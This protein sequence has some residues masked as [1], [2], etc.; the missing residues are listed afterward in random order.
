MY[1][2]KK[3]K[4]IFILLSFI[5]ILSLFILK[6][7]LINLM[8]NNS[9]DLNYNAHIFYYN[10]YANPEF[11]K[12]FRHWNHDVLPHWS[13]KSWDNLPSYDGY[14]TIGSNFYPKLG[15]YSSNNPEIIKKH[16]EM[17]SKAG[18]G[19]IS[20]SWWGKNSFEDK[21]ILS[22]LEIADL[23]DIKVNFHIEPFINRTVLSTIG[24]IKYLIDKYG[25]HNAFYLHEGKPL[26]YIYDS[27]LIPKKDWAT[28]LK[29]NG[30][31]SIRNTHYDS[32]IIGLWVEEEDSLFFKESGFDGF[33][34]YFAS[35]GFTFGS[36]SNNWKYL[37]KWAN[38]NNK[39]FIPCVG[40][41]YNDERVRPWNIKNF[42]DRENGIYYDRHFKKALLSNPEIL[43]I[44]SFNEWHEGTQIE[45]AIP[46]INK[47]FTFE[48]YQNNEPDYYLKRTK[49]WLKRFKNERN[50]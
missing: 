26:F 40:P 15:T 37:S 8:N 11:D 49:F 46:K 13:D 16:M 29:T 27:Y 33:Y 48:N 20:V 31:I 22:I 47:D 19:T 9:L 2:K 30:E 41:G 42:K 45:P 35:N 39:V 4:Y 18:I 36:T 12:S 25:N 1:N 5:F 43:G 38:K 21:N 28:A 3:R 23:Y 10:W 44:T 6:K 50:Y 34:T 17:I 24:A 32:V 14:E 7:N